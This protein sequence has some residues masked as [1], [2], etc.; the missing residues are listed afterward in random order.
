MSIKRFFA[1][2]TSEA[3]RNVREALGPEGVILSN[4]SMDGGIEILA[5]RQDDIAALIPASALQESEAKRS[6]A[7]RTS[8]LH[9][10]RLNKE[11]QANEKKPNETKSGYELQAIFPASPKDLLN[12][13]KKADIAGKDLHASGVS[14]RQNGERKREP[15]YDTGL[16]SYLDSDL[17]SDLDSTTIIASD[18]FAKEQEEHSRAV[19]AA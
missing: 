19:E 9:M 1:K 14:P 13:I 18:T 11:A 17:D 3:L 10:P 12:R 2:T 4:R 7:G 15:D 5:L 8:L 16:D 6:E